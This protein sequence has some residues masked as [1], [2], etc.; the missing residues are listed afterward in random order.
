MDSAEV[1]LNRF[2][3]ERQ[4][5]RLWCHWPWST[6]VLTCDG[7]VVCGC[8]DAFNENPV[9][10]TRSQGAIDIWRGEGFQRMRRGMRENSPPAFCYK[11]GLMEVR[12]AQEGVPDL[13]E[14]PDTPPRVLYVEPT[15][16]CNLRCPQP[17][18]VPEEVYGTRS[19]KLLSY[20]LYA[21]VIDELGPQLERM[22]FYNYGESFIHP[23]AF[24]MIRYAKDVNPSLW[25]WTSTNGHFFDT[26]EK[27]RALVDSGINE[28]Q[29]SIDGATQAVYET[30]RKEGKIEKVF[31]GLRAVA[32]ERDRRGSVFPWISWNYILFRW[33][34]SD[35][36]MERARQ[37][38]IE[39]GV[40]R[41][42]WTTT[43]QP[44]G[45]PS[46]RFVPGTADYE[47][48][49]PGLVG[50]GAQVPNAIRWGGRI[51][52]VAL[53]ERVRTGGDIVARF[54]VT[55]ESELT[56]QPGTAHD[57]RR[58]SLRAK[59]HDHAGALLVE[60]FMYVGFAEPLQPGASAVV[61]LSGTAELEAGRYRLTVDLVREGLWWFEF[62][63][64]EPFGCEF[65]V[66]GPAD[67]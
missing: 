67:A 23:D 16:V 27:V 40:D 12:E 5:K 32:E 52:P 65:E 14:V 29:F 35:E 25:V 50:G 13:A 64:I 3:I 9:G 31:D 4:G 33:N 60:N 30:Y 6:F 61:E 53:P 47:R 38:A 36:E 11:C 18:C 51:E 28:I 42:T 26:A 10:D 45:M 17:A 19:M 15:I 22:V 58:M 59:L 34:D 21:G 24:R 46:E 41:L 20:D 44:L 63:G 37:L 8:G 49:R 62:L 7:V 66:V 56:W 54:Q 55:N 57:V 2:G 48:I 43:D 39:L 1:Q